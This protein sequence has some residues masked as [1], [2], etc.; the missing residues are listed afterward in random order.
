MAYAASL[1]LQPD[2]P[3][4][5]DEL[6]SDL[7]RQLGGQAPDLALLFVGGTHAGRLPS[8]QAAVA[9]ALPQTILLTCTAESI[10]SGGREI[11]EEKIGRAHV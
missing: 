11:E 4:A 6:T 2:I 9:A 10:A 3:A 7:A 1:S 5:V 8:V